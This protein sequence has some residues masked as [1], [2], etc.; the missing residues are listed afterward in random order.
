M[1]VTK[2]EKIASIVI[3][4]VLLIFGFMIYGKISEAQMDKQ[5]IY[6]KAAKIES[7]DLFKYAL[8]TNIGNTFAYG[9]LEAIDTVSYPEINVNFMYIQKVKE[10]YTM[11]TRMVKS[12]KHYVT[13]VYW[14]WDYVGEESKHSNKIKFC[15]VELDYGK[16]NV[17]SAIYIDTIKESSD[18]RYK[19]YGCNSKY[20]GTVFTKISDNTIQDGSNFYEGRSISQTVEYMN[21]SYKVTSVVFWVLWIILIIGLIYVFCYFENKWLE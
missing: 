5:E 6:N 2:R 3:L 12:G 4:S 17:P 21:G 10:K 13:Q 1:R 11:H 20:T 14:T 19:Y 8:E 7:S 16:I 15:G 9:D 18:I